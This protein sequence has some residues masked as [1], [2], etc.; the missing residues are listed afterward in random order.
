VPSPVAVYLGTDRAC[1][2]LGRRP[3]FEPGATELQS[4]P[5]PWNHLSTFDEISTVESLHVHTLP[6]GLLAA[7]GPFPRT[8]CTPSPS[9]YSRYQ[10]ISSSGLI[11]NRDDIKNRVGFLRE[12][13]FSSI[14]SLKKNIVYAISSKI[15]FFT[16][17]I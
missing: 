9:P 6:W 12:W 1:L 11:P 3:C 16:S 10:S 7:S 14:Y 13:K 8:C 4:V 15:M 5:L 2:G 17:K